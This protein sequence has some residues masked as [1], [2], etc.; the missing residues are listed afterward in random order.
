[1]R[2][3]SFIIICLTML[4]TSMLAQNTL[5]IHYKNGTTADVVIADVD[6]LSFTEK[7]DEA[8]SATLV[9]SWLWGNVEAGYYELATFNTDN[10]FTAYDNM[11]SFGY[12]NN[13]YGWYSQLGN[14]LVMRAYGYGYMPR[15]NWFVSTL[16]DNQL[17]VITQMGPFT[18]YRLQPDVIQMKVGETLSL[19]EGEMLVFADGVTAQSV[20]NG[21]KALLPGTTYIIKTDTYTAKTWGYKLVVTSL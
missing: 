15:Y 19:A 1:M 6:S 17:T 13:A 11:F 20:A 18:Y 10:T 16:T 9:G 3:Y 5:R 12:E 14:M 2:S 8:T 21:I 4:C 7:S